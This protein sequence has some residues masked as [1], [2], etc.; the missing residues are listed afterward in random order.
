MTKAKPFLPDISDSLN[1]VKSEH[2]FGELVESGD[3]PRVLQGDRTV[4]LRS[5]IESEKNRSAVTTF[6]ILVQVDVVQVVVGDVDVVLVLVVVEV[7]DC[8]LKYVLFVI[9]VSINL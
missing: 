4:G 7:E 6:A 3:L 2:C 8:R 1:H 5:T 9:R